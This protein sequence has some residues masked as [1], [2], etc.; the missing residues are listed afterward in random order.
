MR[1][2]FPTKTFILP[3]K[4][5][6][7][8][9]IRKLTF[10]HYCHLL[11]DP[12]QWCPFRKRTHFRITLLLS[13]LFCLLQSG[14]VSQPFLDFHNWTLEDYRPVI[15]FN[16]LQFDLSDNWFLMNSEFRLCIFGRNSVRMVCSH[17]ILS[18][19]T[20]YDESLYWWC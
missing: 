13:C 1:D 3:Q 11:S 17:C 20:L 4:H 7:T 12:I 19:R 8:I 15:L 10:I 9:K 16:V 2:L 18:G 14:T 5:N 6:A